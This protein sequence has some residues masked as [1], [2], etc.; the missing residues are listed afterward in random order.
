MPV[1]NSGSSYSD[2]ELAILAIAKDYYQN[3][4]KYL[5]ESLYKLQ[6]IQKSHRVLLQNKTDSKPIIMEQFYV[7]HD[8][9]V[10]ILDQLIQGIEMVESISSDQNL[11]T[12]LR[13][14]L[15]KG[16][17]LSE[18]DLSKG[19]LS[20]VYD[21]PKYMH[22]V[23]YAYD[24]L[25]TFEKTDNRDSSKVDITGEKLYQISKGFETLKNKLNLLLD[26]DNGNTETS[27]FL[28]NSRKIL[29][30]G[31][32]AL[33]TIIQELDNICSAT[34]F[35]PDQDFS[36]VSYSETYSKIFG[37]F[38]R[39]QAKS[40]LDQVSQVV[41]PQSPQ[42]DLR[43]TPRPPLAVKPL[44]RRPLIDRLKQISSPTKKNPT[45]S[46]TEFSSGSTSRGLVASGSNSEEYSVGP[47]SPISQPTPTSLIKKQ[48]GAPNI[49]KRSKMLER[50]RDAIK[51]GQ[52]QREQEKKI[53]SEQKDKQPLFVPRKPRPP[54]E[55][56]ISSR[57]RPS[58][59]PQQLPSVTKPSLVPQP[60]GSQDS[61]RSRPSSV[62]TLPAASEFRPVPVPPS[63]PQPPSSRSRP[64]S[65][66]T[67]KIPPK[68]L[69]PTPPGSRPSLVPKLPAGPMVPK[70]PL[71]PPK[72]G[73][74]N[75]G[76][77]R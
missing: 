61:S 44:I 38:L 47:T 53:K 5:E 11:L 45:S 71:S 41:M 43:P 1:S 56:Q 23:H 34:Y 2:E 59:V 55:S 20:F 76:Q 13:E 54:E 7:L 25:R 33:K 64:S 35:D 4:E 31:E 72:K 16:K 29:K 14:D 52:E 36:K 6:Q 22:F 12:L 65:S 42:E 49:P 37:S 69:V 48:E 24:L 63:G 70:P 26:L 66:S 8:Q 60:P 3:F 30:E 18:E 73:P 39:F 10:E 51:E 75:K 77:K 19:V 57:S 15:L 62:P 21:N 67:P 74:P 40:L 50:L 32:R 68:S 28:E 17:K 27:I 58:S 46:S 9:L